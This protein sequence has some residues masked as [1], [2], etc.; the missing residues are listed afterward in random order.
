MTDYRVAVE[1]A[2]TG[3]IAQALAA[4]TANM[5][6]MHALQGRIQKGF[7]QWKPALLGVVGVFTSGVMLKGLNDIAASGDK[8]VNVLKQMQLQGQSLAQVQAQYNKAVE[9]S[10]KTGR[11]LTEVLK[12]Q[13]A[14][15]YYTASSAEA[16][17][18]SEKLQKMETIYHA[19]SGKSMAA[20]ITPIMKILEESGY[21]N[22]PRGYFGGSYVPHGRTQEHIDKNKELNVIL[23]GITRDIQTTGA[24]VSPAAMLLNYIY[25]RA[26]RYGI[27]TPEALA[28][29]N[30]FLTSI[31]PY[32]IQAF[33]PGVGGGGGGGRGGQSGPGAAMMSFFTKAVQGILSK[34]SAQL[35]GQLGILE[36]HKYIPGSIYDLGSM[37]G[38]KLATQNPYEWVQQILM[39]ALKAHGITSPEDIIRAESQLFGTRMAADRPIAYSL[40]GRA[41]RGYM[42]PYER[43]MRMQN[44]APGIEEGYKITQEMPQVVL[45]RMKNEWARLWDI[46]GTALNPERMKIIHGLSDAFES[47]G[48]AVAKM[49]PAAVRNVGNALAGIAVGLGTASVATVLVAISAMIGPGGWLIA[50]LTALAAI[51]PGLRHAV[52]GMALALMSGDIQKIKTA[53]AG[54]GDA[55]VRAVIDGI[56][57]GLTGAIRAA[58]E[59]GAAVGRS[60]FGGTAPRGYMGGPYVPHDRRPGLQPHAPMV[61]PHPFNPPPMHGF[62]DLLH[63]SSWEP[64]SSGA[65]TVKVNNVIYLDGN[66]IAQAVNEYQSASL[67][68]PT[69]APYFNG[70]DNYTSP[71]YQPISS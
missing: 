43:H 32:D 17:A 45:E 36:D 46:I 6:R 8:V 19:A 28:E 14:V 39:P 15:T 59:A 18:I 40:F 9:V 44:A 26:A 7:E 68:H 57:G 64:G 67:E 27:T 70:L 56:V 21:F 38:A 11:D 33:S 2:L 50:G 12:E 48:N 23:E 65:G 34:K 71:D 55:I 47:I 4:V 53:A 5:V 42:S 52:G 1:L 29:K 24:T 41:R 20:Q 63:K 35:A 69:Q 51:I 62:S 66:A 54:L 3:G 61:L 25:M 22:A 16:M 10:G 31:L 49:D 60:I 30:P 13:K 37:K 58:G